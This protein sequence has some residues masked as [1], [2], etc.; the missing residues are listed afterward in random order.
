VEWPERAQDF[1]PDDYLLVEITFGGS[2]QRNMR[3]S[4][5]SSPA[6]SA[7][8]LEKLKSSLLSSP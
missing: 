1:L 7:D 6:T 2:D 3:F 5:R 8:R 4:L